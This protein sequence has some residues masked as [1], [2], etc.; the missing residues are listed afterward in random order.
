MNEHLATPSF[1]SGL[2]SYLFFFFFE[3]TMKRVERMR[4]HDADGSLLL[5][6][7]G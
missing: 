6:L 3:D 4:G 7:H 1:F 5:C 2:F